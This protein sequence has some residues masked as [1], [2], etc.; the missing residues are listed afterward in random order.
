MN[1]IKIS[2]ATFEIFEE[3]DFEKNHKLSIIINVA[4]VPLFFLFYIA[5]YYLA[6]LLNMSPGKSIFYYFEALSGKNS[7]YF[8][9]IILFNLFLHEAIH[10]FFLYAFTGSKPKIGFKIVYGYAGAPDW[11]IKKNLFYI[12]SLSPFVMMTVVGFILMMVVPLFLHAPIFMAITLNAAGSLGDFWV[13]CKLLRAPHNAYVN[14]S[15]L[16]ARIGY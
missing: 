9:F 15:G 14:D 13:S 1:S 7:I 2:E 3:I 4:S 11:Y 16:C 6:A 12:I 10:G 5:F 8:L